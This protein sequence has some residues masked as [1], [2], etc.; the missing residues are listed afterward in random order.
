MNKKEAEGPWSERTDL[1]R[2]TQFL[3]LRNTDGLS[4]RLLQQHG[5]WQCLLTGHSLLLKCLFTGSYAGSLNSQFRMSG[6]GWG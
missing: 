1:S 6:L 5:I 2:A 4:A 3:L